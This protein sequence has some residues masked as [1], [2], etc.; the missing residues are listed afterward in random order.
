MY[1]GARQA[2]LDAVR[3]NLDYAKTRALIPLQASTY[4]RIAGSFPDIAIG[5]IGP[6]RWRIQNRG[7]LQ[8][9]RFER[10]LFSAVDFGRSH[11]VLGQTRLHGHLY[12]ALDPAI[13][14]PVVALQ[15]SGDPD[16]AP[17]AGVPY[18]IES[19]WDVSALVRVADGVAFRAGGF[20]DGAMHW[21]VP[22][23]GDYRVRVQARDGTTRTRLVTADPTG[24]L[25]FTLGELVDAPWPK[26]PVK[27][28]LTRVGAP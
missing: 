4:A 8:T 16:A 15:S 24:V 20:A 2:A 18:L 26:G 6:R 27:V 1:S 3:Q 13:R 17:E 22:R 25:S 19:G 14:D 23:P 10:G 9:L 5:A 11:G 21:F 12:V 28:V 7:H